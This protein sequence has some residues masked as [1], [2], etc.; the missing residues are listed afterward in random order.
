MTAPL[1]IQ[2]LGHVSLF[3]RDLEASIR[4]YR[5]IL[6]LQDVGRGK[7]GRIAFFTTGQHHHDLSIEAARAEGPARA[8]GEP[9][10]YHIAFQVGSTL[11]ALEEARRWVE[12]HGLAPFGE[13][14][15]QESASFSIRDPDRH[16]IELYVDRRRG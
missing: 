6:G 15:G 3:V 9:G 5:D 4:F 8:K 1:R 16:E 12:A 2:E 13:V 14:N 7:N 11:E 10:L